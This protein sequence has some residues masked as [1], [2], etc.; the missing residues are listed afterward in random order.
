M[1]AE[2]G[3]EAVAEVDNADEVEHVPGEEY[4]MDARIGCQLKILVLQLYS[5]SEDSRVA[6]CRPARFAKVWARELFAVVRNL[7]QTRGAS[8]IHEISGGPEDFAGLYGTCWARLQ[9]RRGFWFKNQVKADE[10]LCCLAASVAA[11]FSS[12]VTGVHARLAGCR[13]GEWS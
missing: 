7:V 1:G 4:V 6:R 5:R 10:I 9:E 13:R 3:A 12:A 11:H 8:R 2:P